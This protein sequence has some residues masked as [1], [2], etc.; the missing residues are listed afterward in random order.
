MK[1]K[2][3]AMIFLAVILPL[4]AA[5]AG[6]DKDSKPRKAKTVIQTG[7]T[8]QVRA[9]IVFSTR[10][11]Q[12]IT[13]WV[14]DRSSN[15]P[16]GLAKR[17]QLPPGLQKQLVRNG[18]LPPGLAK[19]VRPLPIELERMLPVLPAAYHRVAISGSVVIMNRNTRVI[20]DVFAF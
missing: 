20:A 12:I 14:R 3:S 13:G 15:L 9:A 2:F 16:P 4:S 18:T 7:E 10:D 19:K 5:A 8:T 11:R 17:E 1:F 6:K